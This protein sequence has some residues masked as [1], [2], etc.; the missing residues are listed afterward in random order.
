MQQQDPWAV[1]P[2]LGITSNM[3]DMLTSKIQMALGPSGLIPFKA[4]AGL[5]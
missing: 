5:I 4:K 2:H 1:G 3:I